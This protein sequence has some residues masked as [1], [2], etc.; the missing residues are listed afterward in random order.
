MAILVHLTQKSIPEKNGMYL[1]LTYVSLCISAQS[2]LVKSLWRHDL[3]AILLLSIRMLDISQLE[4]CCICSLT[5][6][7]KHLLC[8]PLVR[9]KIRTFSYM[10]V[11]ALQLQLSLK[12]RCGGVWKIKKSPY[13][14]CE[15][16]LDAFCLLQVQS[17]LKDQWVMAVAIPMLSAIV[18]GKQ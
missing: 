2:W 17:Q 9:V 18:L 12:A 8:S 14:L 3:Q 13:V 5:S 7:C 10:L 1:M 15:S 11:F 16:V 4:N 6:R